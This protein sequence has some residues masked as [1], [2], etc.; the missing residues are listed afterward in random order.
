M[1]EINRSM[2]KSI[3]DLEETCILFNLNEDVVIHIPKMW[4]K[5]LPGSR[6]TAQ[7]N[8]V[9]GTKDRLQVPE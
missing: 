1:M 7:S 2:K 5:P 4:G 3:I 9:A 8:C 6:W